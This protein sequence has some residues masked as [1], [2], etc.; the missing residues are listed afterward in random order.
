M[1]GVSQVIKLPRDTP[2]LLAAGRLQDRAAKLGGCVATSTNQQGC[3]NIGTHHHFVS[4]A[5]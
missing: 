2:S 5:D 3:G 1:F 4:R